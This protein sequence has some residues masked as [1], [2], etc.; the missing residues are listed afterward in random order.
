MTLRLLLASLALFTSVSAYVPAVS[1]HT[2]LPQALVEY[3]A[4]HPDATPAEIEAFMAEDPDTYDDRYKT[5]VFEQIRNPQDATFL[6]VVGDFIVL[7]VEHI[8][9][10]LDHILFVLS[11]VLFFTSLRQ[12]LKLVTAFTVAHSITIILAGTEVLR[13]SSQIV[14]PLIAFSIAYVAVTSA[15]LRR[16]DFFASNR[17]KILSVL[18]FGLFHGMG[19]AGLLEEIAI[20]RETFLEA[21]ISFN[22]GIEIG[23]LCILAVALPVLYLLRDRSWYPLLMKIFAVIISAFA[24]FVMMERLTG[25]A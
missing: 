7:G 8:L 23:Q 22:I 25:Q 19:F 2:L 13:V 1:A 6:D 14:E 12:V 9:G 5:K 16:Y 15:F 17:N 20:P 4:E 11:L 24:L 10:G 3:M 18:F 21:L